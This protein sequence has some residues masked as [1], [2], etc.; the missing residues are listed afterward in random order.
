MHTQLKKME[1]AWLFCHRRQAMLFFDL[2]KAIIEGTAIAILDGSH[3]NDWGTAAWCILSHT[4][5]EQQWM[6]V[7]HTWTEMGPLSIL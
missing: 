1:H 5:E 7:Y 6:T 4:R 2:V 3:K